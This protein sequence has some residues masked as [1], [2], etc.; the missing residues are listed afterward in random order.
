MCNCASGCV[1]GA[2]GCKGRDVGELGRGWGG[3]VG[4][5]MGVSGAMSTRCDMS[6]VSGVCVV[7]KSVAK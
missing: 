4:D 1:L 6:M 7:G 3:C 2:L 5:D